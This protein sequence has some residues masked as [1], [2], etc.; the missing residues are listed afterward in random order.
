MMF[1]YMRTRVLLILVGWMEYFFVPYKRVR[2]AAAWLLD[3][4]HGWIGE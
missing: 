1:S 4:R 3:I 2:L